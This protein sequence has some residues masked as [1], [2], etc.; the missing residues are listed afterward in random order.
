MAAPAV[1]GLGVEQKTYQNDVVI[2]KGRKVEI[3]SMEFHE[4]ETDLMK[5]TGGLKKEGVS[6]KRIHYWPCLDDI[7]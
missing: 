3:R 5:H 4:T 6:P 1:G 2:R 7:H